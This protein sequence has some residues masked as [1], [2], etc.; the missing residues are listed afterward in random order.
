[1]GGTA[2]SASASSRVRCDVKG[3]ASAL[4]LPSEPEP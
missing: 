3:G 1:L 2:A 4:A